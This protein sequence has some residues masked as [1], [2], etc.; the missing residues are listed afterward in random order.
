MSLYL[1]N[2]N[3]A[4]HEKPSTNEDVVVSSSNLQYDDVIVP[5]LSGNNKAVVLLATENEYE[6]CIPP[7]VAKNVGDVVISS[8]KSTT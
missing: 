5:L 4:V 6:V 1:I 3:L 2:Q 7:P 8:P